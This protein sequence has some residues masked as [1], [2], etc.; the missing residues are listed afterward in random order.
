VKW[1]EEDQVMR[2]LAPFTARKD[3][4]Q[5]RANQKGRGNLATSPAGLYT[6]TTYP[7]ANNATESWDWTS[8]VSGN[9]RLPNTGSSARIYV[10]DTGVNVNHQEF[11]TGGRSRV[12]VSV[13]YVTTNNTG[14]A[15]C[16]G[17][18]T[19]CAGSVAGQYRGVATGAEL[20]NVRVLNCAGSGTNANV[21]A[22][23][24]YVAQQVTSG[25]MTIL[26]ASLGGGASS[27]TDSAINN[28]AA[29]GV[30]PVV[31][32]GNDSNANACNYSPA[33][34]A[35]AITVGAMNKDDTRA[36]F[37]NSGNCVNVFSPGQNIHS[38]WY[39]STTTYNTISG[40]SMATPLTAG[41][42]AIYGTLSGNANQR[43]ANVKSAIN[44]YSSS[45]VLT[46]AGLAGTPNLVINSQW[47]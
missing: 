16:N 10:V 38:S 42:I 4:G 25:R 45:G 2:A 20:G 27:T 22:G 5:M 18:G 17:H 24:N 11:V 46:S 23:F 15:D 6:G 7:N 47:N 30:I 9:Y 29:A 13:D 28:G 21:V 14:G 19:H 26:S 12:V 37:S 1:V 31:A 40:T 8:A 34:A 39:T 32:A 35:Q 44:Q 43:V 36:S 41:A 3:W 33:G